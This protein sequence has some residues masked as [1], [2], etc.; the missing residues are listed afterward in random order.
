VTTVFINTD[1][2]SLPAWF[3][4]LGAPMFCKP[5]TLPSFTLHFIDTNSMETGLDLTHSQSLCTYSLSWLLSNIHHSSFDMHA[6]EI[7]SKAVHLPHHSQT[8][9]NLIL[10]R[11]VHMQAD[12]FNHSSCHNHLPHNSSSPCNKPICHCNCDRLC[13]GLW[14]CKT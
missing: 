8:T 1:L 13:Y 4:S 3:L 5:L 11:P 14:H 10:L 2:D 6:G 7:C 12:R 9:T